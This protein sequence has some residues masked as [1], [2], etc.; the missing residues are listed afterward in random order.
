MIR[1]VVSM[2]PVCTVARNLHR[3][4]TMQVSRPPERGKILFLFQVVAL[5]APMRRVEMA[6]MLTL[7]RNL[8]LCKTNPVL[9]AMLEHNQITSMVVL[10]TNTRMLGI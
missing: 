10:P 9:G 1:T 2:T 8:I 3:A 5:E 6:G 4:I 7:S